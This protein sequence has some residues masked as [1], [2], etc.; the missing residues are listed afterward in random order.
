[1]SCD[2][3]EILQGSPLLNA[4]VKGGFVEEVEDKGEVEGRGRWTNSA[5]EEQTAS[6]WTANR[7][8]LCR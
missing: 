3:E 6:S 2:N 8:G 1:M 5:W 4:H 7:M